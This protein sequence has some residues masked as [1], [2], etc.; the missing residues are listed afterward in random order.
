MVK[1]SILLVA[2]MA[3][4]APASA[5]TYK[6]KDASGKLSF[7]QQPCPQEA[8]AERIKLSAEWQLLKSEP[9]GAW[10]T[11]EIQGYDE[12]YF[13]PVNIV[14]VDGY[15]R[16]AFKQVVTRKNGGSREPDRLF[17][18]YADCATGKFSNVKMQREQRPGTPDSAWSAH[19]W[20]MGP[21]ESAPKVLAAACGKKP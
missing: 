17:F 20:M 8:Q 12:V 3:A 4:A 14:A 13:D 9:L 18:F 15:P 10:G 16:V 6:C 21:P 11:T 19:H 5:A 7:Q 2:L 1:R